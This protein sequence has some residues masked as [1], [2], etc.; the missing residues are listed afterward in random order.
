MALTQTQTPTPKKQDLTTELARPSQVG[1]RNAWTWRPLATL[2]PAQVADILRRAS[3]GDAADYLVAAADI[4]EKDLHYRAV[5]QTRKLAVAGLPLVVSPADDSALATK[6]ADLVRAQ[7]EALDMTSVNLALMDAVARGY[8]VAELVWAPTGGQW[9]IAHVLAREPQ[10]FTWDRDTGC[11]LRLADGTLQ[12]AE[13]PP[14]KMVLHAP[15]AHTATPVMGGIA[16]SALWAWVFKSYAM[17]DWARFCE[18]FGQPVRIGKYD[19][20]ATPQDV[21]IL[22]RA[23]FELGS[24]AAAILPQSMAVELVESGSKTA[25][26][27]IY[28]R[29]IDYMDAQVSKCV[30]GQTLTTDAGKTG[31]LAQARVHD[32][33]REDLLKYDARALAQTLRT[34]LAAPLVALNL[35]PGAPVPL[36]A[37]YV[38]EPEDL[39]ALHEQVIGLAGAGL[40]VPLRWVREKWGIPEPEAGEA[41]LGAPAAP[42]VP[43]APGAPATPGAALP[44]AHAVHAAQPETKPDP[45]PDPTPVSYLSQA[46]ARQAAPAWN[47][48]LAQVQTLVASAQSLPELREALLGAYGNLDTTDLTLVMGLGTAVADLAGRFDVA[49]EDQ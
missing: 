7:F 29:L 32:G 13:L 49:Q 28:A 40:G 47:Q 34:Q 10:W 39:A 8:A 23:V 1:L 43:V 33:V 6:A 2:T 5:L 37:L 9:Q 11:E 24:D 38:A 12:G 21:A 16:R 27:E 41:V 45:D 20:S 15:G 26:A 48:V 44:V 25:S 4:E 30:L 46:M 3:Q 22:R 42:A 31:S 14:Y 35:G 18:L 17:R 36:V 19:A